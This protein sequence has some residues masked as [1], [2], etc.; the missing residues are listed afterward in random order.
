MHLS[1]AQADTLVRE[2]SG[3]VEGLRRLKFRTPV[4]VQ[5]IENKAAREAFKS[6]ISP[7]S[8]VQLRHATNAYVQLGLIPPGADLL[9]GILNTAEHDVLG[10]YEPGSKTFFLMSNVSA[11]EVRSVIAHELTHA[12]EDQNYDLAALAKKARNEDHA[13]AITALI[14]G[15]ATVVMLAFLS[16]EENEQVAK[17][18]LEK[19]ESQRVERVGIAPSFTQRTLV[20][21]YILGFT[22][23]LRGKPWGWI[24]EG[25]VYLS[26]LERAYARPP[27]ST[28]QVLHP[29]QYWKDV[30]TASPV[31]NLPDLS[32]ALG[33]GWAK[34]LDGAIG[35]LG[36]AVLTGSNERLGMPWALLP[37]RWTNPAAVGNAGDVYQHYVNGEQKVTVLLTRWESP[38]DAEEFGRALVRKGRYFVRYGVNFLMLSGDFGDKAEALAA[39]AMAG[40]SFYADE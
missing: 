8:E 24:T 1:P 26:D 32:R 2:I 19:N 22:F 18:Q 6:K 39:A 37:S 4:T 40:R 7:E 38:G 34:A 5:V 11:G 9:R 15:S 31:L 10:Y 29:E 20:L 27:D 30:P 21:P 36:L 13:T 14:E 35:E 17:R 23:L 33:P 28:R 25:G 16:R 3:K 12:L